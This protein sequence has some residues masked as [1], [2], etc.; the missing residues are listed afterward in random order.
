MAPL[1]PKGPIPLDWGIVRPD[2]RGRVVTVE[3]LYAAAHAGDLEAVRRCAVP[4]RLDEPANAS[5]WSALMVAAARGH[6][7]VVR[8]LLDAGARPDLVSDDAD[9]ALSLAVTRGHVEAARLLIGDRR[10]DVNARDGRGWT[11]LQS[12]ALRG[13]DEIVGLLLERDDLAANRADVD[14][15]TALIWAASAGHASIVRRLAADPRV[16]VAHPAADGVTA[17]AAA[18]DAGLPELAEELERLESGDDRPSVRPG[19]IDV[20]PPAPPVP[21]GARPIREPKHAFEER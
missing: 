20:P 10:V 18:R 14:G 17:A 16:A 1:N 19:D 3:T 9:T 6:S 21:P 4:E 11:P 2:T 7:D 13:Y 12:A 8:W 15:R 5:G